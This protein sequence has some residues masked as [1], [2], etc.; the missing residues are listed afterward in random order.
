MLPRRNREHRNQI[1]RP[2]PIK[3]RRL[4]RNQRKSPVRNTSNACGGYR[5]IWRISQPSPTGRRNRGV[6]PHRRQLLRPRHRICHLWGRRIT[7][8]M[9]F[10]PD[11]RR[12]LLE[13]RNRAHRLFRVTASPVRLPLRNPWFE[14]GVCNSLYVYDMSGRKKRKDG[15]IY[16]RRDL[17]PSLRPGG[18]LCVDCRQHPQQSRLSRDLDLFKG[19]N[20]RPRRS[21][22]IQ[23]C[24]GLNWTT[25]SGRVSP[26]A[27]GTRART[28]VTVFY[29]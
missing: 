21:C 23:P 2:D 10:S 25:R 28:S 26:R 16:D 17:H 4:P 1:P 9:N 24:R 15:G 5:Q 22:M 18:N 3:V 29:V 13:R 19:L 12:G 27:T 6:F 14:L 11:L 7:S 8:S 20:R